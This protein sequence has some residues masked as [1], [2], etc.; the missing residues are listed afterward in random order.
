MLDECEPLLETIEPEEGCD[1]YN[2]CGGLYLGCCGLDEPC[3]LTCDVLGG[4][5][6]G[7]RFDATMAPTFVPSAVPSRSL[8]PTDSM[9]PTA[10]AYPTQTRNPTSTVSP[11]QSL[12][13]SKSPAPSIS[14][15]PT[16]SSAPSRSQKPSFTASPS[17]SQSPSVSASPTITPRPSLSTTPSISIIPSQ[18][19]VPSVPI[20]PSSSQPTSITQVPSSVLPTISPGPTAPTISP[21]PTAVPSFTP[22]VNP[23]VAEPSTLP[24][25]PAPS[26]ETVGI[27]LDPFTLEY[28]LTLTRTVAQSDLVDLTSLTNAYLQN[29]MLGAFQSQEVLMVDFV[30]GYQSYQEVAESSVVL[31]SFQSTAVF[32]A[33]SPQLPSR[34]ELDAELANAFRGMALDGY[35]G[36]VQALPTTNLF[37]TTTQIYLVQSSPESS[38]SRNEKSGTAILATCFGFVILASALL[39]F[40]LYRRRRKRRRRQASDSF[41]KSVADLDSSMSGRTLSQSNEG[42]SSLH[43]SEELE[44][45]EVTLCESAD[46]MDDLRRLVSEESHCEMIFVEQM[47]NVVEDELSMEE[48]TSDFVSIF[49]SVH[50]SEYG[51]TYASFDDSSYGSHCGGSSNDESV[52]GETSSFDIER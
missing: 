42:Q 32:D 49:K 31:V 37:T 7:C 23:V 20:Q 36:M 52:I 13:P 46:Q 2:F 33:D 29:Y 4:F 22:S 26:I 44:K 19:M 3:P 28:E 48:E 5:V 11:S 9:F 38:T 16:L 45:I 18:S 41:M 27:S 34:V 30:T 10:S 1:C 6:A 15:E 40:A 39:S 8:S 21:A 14:Q 25:T 43:G 35:L 47:T 17:E 24:G 51:A 12:V 50:V